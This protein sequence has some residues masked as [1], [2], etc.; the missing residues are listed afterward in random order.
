[1]KLFTVSDGI[2]PRT[3][4]LGVYPWGER[5]SFTSGWL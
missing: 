4:N 3:L 5:G 2:P 1:M